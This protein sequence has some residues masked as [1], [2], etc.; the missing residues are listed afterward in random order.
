[1]LRATISH[2]KN[3][4][5]TVVCTVCGKEFQCKKYR[6]NT[7]KY[8]SRECWSHRRVPNFRPCKTCGNLFDS[9]DPRVKFCSPECVIQWRTGETSPVWKGG[10]SAATKRGKLKGELAK[11]RKAVLQRDSYT[12]QRCGKKGNDL[13][14]H[15][16][17]PLADYPQLAL[18]VSNGMTVC[19][20]C[21]E[22]IH[23]RP[24]T[25]P[26]KYPKHCAECGQTTSGRSLRCRSCSI[27]AGW[28]TRR[29]KAG[30][31]MPNLRGRLYQ[32]ERSGVL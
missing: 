16:V 26:S 13:H 3:T 27:R 17:K 7:A 5:I 22:K 14:A 6:A 4:Q 31:D 15:H 9:R 8:C 19:V 10:D 25:G 11:W 21:H 28:K 32:A 18:D 30:K 23:G 12:C 24:I 29:R 2:M 20:P 1:M